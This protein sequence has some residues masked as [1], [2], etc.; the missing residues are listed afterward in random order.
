MAMTKR[1]IKG[2]KGVENIY[3]QHEPYICQL[4][5]ALSKGRLSEPAY[6]HVTPTV[7]Y[8][9]L[10]KLMLPLLFRST[11]RNDLI[12]AVGRTMLLYLS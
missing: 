6:P 4:I 7:A 12:L 10:T 5:D 11:N 2:L 3:T 1:F 9:F 8:V